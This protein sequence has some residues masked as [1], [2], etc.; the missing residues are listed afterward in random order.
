MSIRSG[1]LPSQTINDFR[2]IQIILEHEYSNS[3]V[4]NHSCPRVID[5]V[6][7]RMLVE[8]LK[9]EEISIIESHVVD[10][11]EYSIVFS[12]NEDETTKITVCFQE[13]QI[14]KTKLTI[15][16]KHEKIRLQSF[17]DVWM[18]NSS[19][20]DQIMGSSDPNEEKW[21]L[22][23][24]YNYKIA[25]TFMPIYAKTIY[26]YFGNPK[27][28]LDP[29]S[30]LGDRML[31][32]EVSEIEKYIGFDPNANLRP[33][34]SN[35]M[36]FLGH[37]VVELSSEY[38]RFSNSYEI[39][40]QP[41]EI[42]AQYLSS[43]SVDFIFTSPPFFDYEVYDTSNPVYDNWLSDFYEPLFIQCERSLK[44]NCYAC[45]Y[46]N[47]TSSGKIETFLK[48]RVER[49][50]N[51]IL[52]TKRIGFQGIWSKKIRKIWVFKKV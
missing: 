1:L 37:S 41:F 8:K 49:I 7:L 22:C 30:G 16:K 25:T 5:S 35:M 26:Q 4:K 11:L 2:E 47:D 32:A 38:M 15:V 9:N 10:N 31:G 39:H 34:Y 48:E 45:I 33:G 29:C 23:N 50:C 44:P 43:N 6:N 17:W 14:L 52:E 12:A 36:S 18:S 40:T 21:R 3:I 51:L 46:I 13:D 28:V 19:F 42:G 20:R 24:K 27:I